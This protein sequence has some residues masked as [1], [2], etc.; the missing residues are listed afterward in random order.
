M[1]ALGD[2]YDADIVGYI[3]LTNDYQFEITYDVAAED[4]Y[5]IV[6]ELSSNSNV[7][8]AS[9]NPVIESDFDFAPNDPWN[10]NETIDWSVTILPAQIGELSSWML[11]G[12]GSTR[13]RCQKLI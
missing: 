8:F 7:E 9:I 2:T 10:I 3:E 12:H 6:A 13:N 5:D 11:W 4:I 1:E